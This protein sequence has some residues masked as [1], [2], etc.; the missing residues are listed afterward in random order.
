M[1]S[2]GTLAISNPDLAQRLINSWEL[3]KTVDQ[4]TWYAGNEK[5]YT[6]YRFYDPT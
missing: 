1:I 6:D 2:F 3:N 5:G 4:S